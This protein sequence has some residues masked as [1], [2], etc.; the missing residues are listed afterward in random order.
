MSIYTIVSHVVYTHVMDDLKYTRDKKKYPRRKKND[1]RFLSL[2]FLPM[3]C[4]NDTDALAVL[5]LLD[6]S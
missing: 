5:K 1:A 3:I 4:V 6:Q 2:F